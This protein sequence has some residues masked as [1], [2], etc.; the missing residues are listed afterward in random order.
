MVLANYAI[1][2]T[3]FALPARYGLG[4]LPI[5]AVCAAS[6]VRSSAGRAL[7]G[8][9]ALAIATIMLVTIVTTVIS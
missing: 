8:V 3:V 9:V 4:L 7:F 6:T 1:L 2:G 5:I